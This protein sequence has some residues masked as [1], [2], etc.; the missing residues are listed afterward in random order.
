MRI[1]IVGLAAVLAL[2]AGASAGRAPQ[3][4]S[5]K[6]VALAAL[7]RQAAV[8][9]PGARGGGDDSCRWANDRECDEPGVGTGACTSGTD[10]SDCRW[11]IGGEADACQWARDGECDEP[12]IG[13]GACVQGSD[14]SDCPGVSRLRFRNDSCATAFNG[15]CNEPNQ[16][17]IQGDG[18]CEIRTDRRDCVGAE[19]PL[20]LNDHFFGRDDRIFM[21]RSQD[22]WR[23][24]GQIH[25]DDGSACT[26]TLVGVNVLITAAHCIHTDG[27]IA[28]AGRFETGPAGRMSEARIT[29]YLLDP[30]FDYRRF[31]GGNDIDGL[32]W[33]LL[34]IDR[35]LGRQLGW[36]PMRNLTGQGQGAWRAARLDQAGYSWDTGEHLSG[37]IGC[38]MTE[39]FPDNTFAHECDT[40]RGDSGSPF[41]IRDGGR[42]YVVGVDSNFRSNPKGPRTYIAVSAAS[43]IEHLNAFS[44]GRTGTPVGGATGT[45]RK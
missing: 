24:I 43:F 14:R 34:R 42:W 6:P 31:V 9:K 1:A 36:L 12:G 26:A 13:T 17:G 3:T 32:D 29:A 19:R 27:R 2:A 44:A 40:T 33:A 15:V 45:R 4:P 28:A 7:L 8:A 20:T 18:S 22:P 5:D 10:A 38:R 30:R 21:D 39:V 25:M 16:P 41:M 23:V 35:P 11:L 37:N